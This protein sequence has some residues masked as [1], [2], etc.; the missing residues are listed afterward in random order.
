LKARSS[1]LYPPGT[2]MPKYIPGHW[3]PFCRLLLLEGLR[4]RYS[5]P[6]PRGMNA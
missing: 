2:G 6:P 4:C 5:N 3:V 1:Y